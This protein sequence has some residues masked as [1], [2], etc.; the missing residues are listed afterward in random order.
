MMRS[1]AFEPL[2]LKVQFNYCHL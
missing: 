2:D 1:F